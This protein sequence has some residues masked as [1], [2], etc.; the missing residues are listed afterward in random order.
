MTDL[1]KTISKYAGNVLKFELE[2][3][4]IS[5]KME[6]ASLKAQFSRQEMIKV[7]ISLYQYPLRL[8]RRLE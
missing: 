6:E 7:I 1:F 8:V 3:K 4:D 2:A 5:Q